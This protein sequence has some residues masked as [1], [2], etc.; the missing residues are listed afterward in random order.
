MDVGE[1]IE[2]HYQKLFLP[3]LIG[4][5]ISLL[6]LSFIALNDYLGIYLLYS[7]I[8][9]ISYHLLLCL[10]VL[11]LWFKIMYIISLMIQS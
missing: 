8:S 4:N 2:Y 6:N 3:V 9:F 1:D 10:V 5:D 7:L 11:A